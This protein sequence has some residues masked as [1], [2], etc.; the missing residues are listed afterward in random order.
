[1]KSISSIICHYLIKIFS[2]VSSKPVW[3]YLIL[4]TLLTF[5]AQYY[6]VI[7]SDSFY[8]HINNLYKTNYFM[9]S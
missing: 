9:K 5:S 4:C 8:C 6:G 2:D 3:L 1:M 7:F